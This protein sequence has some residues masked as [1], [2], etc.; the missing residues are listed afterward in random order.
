MLYSNGPRT[1]PSGKPWS[2]SLQ[3]Q[4]DAFIFVFCQRFDK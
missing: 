2:R 3:E 4:N 1:D